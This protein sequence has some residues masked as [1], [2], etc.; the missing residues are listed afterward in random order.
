M[1]KIK[2]EGK[3]DLNKKTISRL[4]DP[5]MNQVKGGAAGFTSI[6]RNCTQPSFCDIEK[7]TDGLFCRE[8]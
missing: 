6:G 3:L 5:Q 4:S 2:L 7:W 8:R 1:K